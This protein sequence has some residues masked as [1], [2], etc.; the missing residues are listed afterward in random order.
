MAASWYVINNA[1]NYNNAHPMECDCANDCSCFSCGDSSEPYDRQLEDLINSDWRKTSA[2]R[3]KAVLQFDTISRRGMAYVRLQFG[4]WLESLNTPQEVI[5][6]HHS[7]ELLPRVT[8]EFKKVLKETAQ[9]RYLALFK[10]QQ[11]A[12][13]E[14]KAAPEE[15]SCSPA[16]K[17]FLDDPRS[18]F[19]CFGSQNA[20]ALTLFGQLQRKANVD[21]ALATKTEE[22]KSAFASLVGP[23]Y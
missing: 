5:D 15:K 3:V 1:I 14:A 6:A 18:H 23:N 19:C 10:V 12:A 16:T 11:E 21:E 4:L 13:R 7:I 2:D 17:T 20:S 9:L 22:V 8:G